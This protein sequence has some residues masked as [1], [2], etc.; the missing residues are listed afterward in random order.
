MSEAEVFWI[1]GPVLKAHPRGVFSMKE[2][3]SGGPKRLAAEVIRLESEAITVQV[4]EDTTGLKPGIRITGS[5]MPL[6]VELGPG[7]LGQMFDGIQR[8][9]DRLA[10]AYGDFIGAGSDLPNLDRER[11]WDYTPVAREGDAVEGGKVLGSIRETPHLV[12]R[13]LVRP[14][15]KSRNSVLR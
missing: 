3:V 13:V 6:S 4:F 12:S 9:L 15:N 1:N 2:A 7:L 14:K 10:G 5:G 11:E 8:P